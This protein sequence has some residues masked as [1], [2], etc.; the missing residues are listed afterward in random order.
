MCTVP[1]KLTFRD[2]ATRFQAELTLKKACKVKCS[3]P[4]P[5]QLRSIMDD[6]VKVCKPANSGCF[7]Q[8]KVDMDKLIV[9][10]R[11]RSDNGWRNLE[12]TAKIPLDI[13]DPA[14]MVAAEDEV[15]DMTPLS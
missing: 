3:T 8:T 6:L 4:Y 10:A 15:V 11:A 5:K 9:T 14:E 1:V 7:I 13:L 2:K 12:N